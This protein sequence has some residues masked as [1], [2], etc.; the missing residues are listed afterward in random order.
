MGYKKILRLLIAENP[1]LTQEVVRTVNHLLEFQSKHPQIADLALVA[2]TPAPAPTS[3]SVFSVQA[4]ASGIMGFTPKAL[5]S[6]SSLQ[7]TRSPSQ[8]SLLPP[9]P[10]SLTLE[11]QLLRGPS[12]FDPPRRPNSSA[13]S[14]KSMPGVDRVSR[15]IS[16]V[17]GMFVQELG[18]IF[19]QLK[20]QDGLSILGM[21]SEDH[22][23]ISTEKN[24]IPNAE[25][26]QF[27]IAYYSQ[28]VGGQDGV[29]ATE[30]PSLSDV[31]EESTPILPEPSKSLT[32]HDQKDVALPP[33]KPEDDAPM[34]GSTA[35]GGRGGTIKKMSSTPDLRAAI[36]P[37]LETRRNSDDRASLE[38]S[39]ATRGA[40]F[41]LAQ[42][43]ELLR[44]SHP[45]NVLKVQ[46][47]P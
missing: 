40:A 18:K 22:G 28:L 6:R 32:E 4:R 2:P 41:E 30:L 35:Q 11:R 47:S 19:P 39:R 38:V 15:A 33:D 12:P 24:Y 13:S 42:E 34:S 7:L 1:E 29:S 17:R 45:D 36:R 21:S 8:S 37:T 26:I 46:P 43:E 14:V 31:S 23:D 16:E 3:D 25:Q 5:L 20:D 27:T 10:R 9:R 44:K